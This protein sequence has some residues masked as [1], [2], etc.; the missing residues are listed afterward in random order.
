MKD[1][2]EITLDFET[3]Y[4][5]KSKYSLAANGM[6]YEKY[7]RDDKFEVIGLAVK[8]GNRNTEW[9]S[10]REIQ[11]WINHIEVAY[12]WEN[13][14]LIAQNAVFDASILGLK[15]NVYPGQIADTMLMSKAVQ[16]WDGNSLDVITRQLRTKYGWICVQNNDGSTW[17]GSAIGENEQLKQFAIDKGTEVH[18][19]DGKH[20]CDFTDEEYDAYAQYCITDVDLTWSAYRFFLDYYGF[21]EQEIDVMTTSIEMYTYPVMELDTKVLEE[22]KANVNQLREESLARAGVT[23]EEVRSDA[24]FAEALMKLGVEPP[25]KINT[26]GEVK[27]A[28]AKKDLE[29]LKLLEHED[30]GVRELAQARFDNKSSQ[31]VTRVEDF[32]SKAERGKLCVGIEYYGARTGRFGGFEGNLQNLNRNKV[33]GKDTPYGRLVFY[34]GKA[35]RFMKLG[36]D[37]KVLLARAGWV[38]NDEDELHEV[39]LRDSVKAP[40]GKTLVVNDLSQIECVSG[41]SIVLTD[42][43]LKKIC[44]I[45]TSDLVFDGLEYVKH[46]GVMFKGVKDVIEYC[47]V[48]GTPDHVVYTRDGK[49]ISLDQAAFSKAELSTGGDE[50]EK[51]W[52]MASTE[53]TYSSNDENDQSVVP[54]PVWFGASSSNWRSKKWCF[55]RLSKVWQRKRKG[56]RRFTKKT[57]QSVACQVQRLTRESEGGQVYEQNL[58]KRRKPLQKLRRIC[59]IYVGTRSERGLFWLGARPHRY[60]RTLRKG[61]ST[62]RNARTKRANKGLQ[63]YG[64]LQWRDNVGIEV[65]QNLRTTFSSRQCE[66]NGTRWTN[67][68]GDNSSV[69]RT[70]ARALDIRKRKYDTYRVHSQVQQWESWADAPTTSDKSTRFTKLGNPIVGTIPVYDIINCGARHRFCCNGVIVSNCRVLAYTAYEQWVLDAFVAKKDIYKAQAS[71][72]FGVPYEEITKSMRFVGKSQILGLGFQAGEN[73]LRVVLGKRSEDFSSEELQGWVKSYRASVPNI[74]AFWRKYKAVLRAMVQGMNVGIDDKGILQLEGNCVVLPNG[75]KLVYRDIRCEKNENGFDQYIYWGR[76]IRTK[77]PDWENTFEGRM[78]ENAVQALAR[79]VLTTQM[80]WIKAEFRKRGWSR[81]DAHLAMQVHDELIVCCREDIAEEALEIM[82]H[83]MAKP[84]HW[85]ADLPLGSDGD[86]AK[87]YGCAK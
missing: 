21:P 57:L 23:L 31:A 5:K 12:G 27:Y 14:R 53:Q 58:C 59:P 54:M 3:Y 62:F 73:G 82:Q 42:G 28:F 78:V 80:G 24:K 46:D 18:D 20:L 43:G 33:V 72:S 1:L 8:V 60:K 45:S 77:K 81:D 86:I 37:G 48:V 7:I 83:Y 17:V 11:D 10:P 13:V 66:Q 19:A 56:L 74:V 52:E 6:T 65:C 61:K 26:K 68:K 40:K 55:D 76:N 50:W 30:E 9:L 69:R 67:T 29:F 4:C 47:G 51:V 63:R 16:Q 49:P 2:I 15:F 64:Y 75:M 85:A 41:D 32:L 71:K 44:D 87:R 38:E 39:G 79:I 84:P 36:E 34:K 35:D 25:T 70:K 22:V